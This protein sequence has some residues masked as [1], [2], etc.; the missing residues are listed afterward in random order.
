MMP[1]WWKR[2]EQVHARVRPK[3]KEIK[4]GYSEPAFTTTAP[5]SHSHSISKEG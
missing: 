2:D 1:P 4:M 3:E 5:I